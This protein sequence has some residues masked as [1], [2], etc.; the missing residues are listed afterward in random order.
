MGSVPCLIP[1]LCLKISRQDNGLLS[2][3][4][5]SSYLFGLK[6]HPLYVVVGI[7]NA[8]GLKLGQTITNFYYVLATDLQMRIIIS[9][10]NSNI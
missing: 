9:G 7:I 3:I 10:M 5:C 1:L 4:S 6:F 8:C 2:P